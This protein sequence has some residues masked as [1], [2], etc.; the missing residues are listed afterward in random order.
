MVGAARHRARAV[1]AGAQDPVPDVQRDAEIALLAVE[2]VGEM[3]L[4]DLAQPA[5]P[6]RERQVL[7]AVAELVAGEDQGPAAMAAAAPAAPPI[8]QPI[9]RVS[10][11]IGGRVV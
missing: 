4:L 3:M 11:R 2:V 5:V 6:G 7:D 9:G 8:N 10:S 1:V